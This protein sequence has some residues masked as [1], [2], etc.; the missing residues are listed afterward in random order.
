MGSLTL[1]TDSTPSSTHVGVT[2]VDGVTWTI[3][4]SAPDVVSVVTDGNGFTVSAV[5]TGNATITVIPY[6]G[7]PVIVEVMVSVGPLHDV[8]VIETGGI[9]VEVSPQQATVG[10]TVTV[11]YTLDRGKYLDSIRVTSSDG[12]EITLIEKDSANRWFVMPDSDVTVQAVA[13]G[14]Q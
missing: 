14:I 12:S 4:N 13:Y 11:H 1:Y 10:Q 9:T 2:T 8:N 7:E 5:S 3:S 6:V